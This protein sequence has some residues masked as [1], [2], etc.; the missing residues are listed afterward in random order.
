MLTYVFERNSKSPLYEQLYNLIK[1][2]ILSGNI[3]GGDRLPSKREFAAH[4][5]ISKVTV[6]AAY[7]ALISEGYVYSLEKRGYYDR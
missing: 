5:G 7:S 2:D 6:E 4:L 1:A 3:K